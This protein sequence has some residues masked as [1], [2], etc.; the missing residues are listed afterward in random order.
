MQLHLEHSGGI[1]LAW[2]CF[3][4]PVSLE[5][6]YLIYFKGDEP[7]LGSKKLSTHGL[8]CQTKS[9]LGTASAK[10]KRMQCKER[11]HVCLP[12]PDFLPDQPIFFIMNSRRDTHAENSEH[13]QY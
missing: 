5:N 2:Y 1:M 8:P 3:P 12:P 10:E 9:S 11:S 7:S 13:I 4:I 6:G